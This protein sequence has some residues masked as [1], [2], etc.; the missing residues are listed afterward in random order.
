MVMEIAKNPESTLET[1]TLGVPDEFNF[2]HCLKFLNRSTKECLHR[3]HGSSWIKLVK[4]SGQLV[5]I[6][7]YAVENQLYVDLHAPLSFS[8]KQQLIEYLEQVFDLR[9]D[10]TQFYLAMVQDP[11]MSPL[12]DS[13]HGLRLIGMPELFEALC[14]S[15]IG[16][17]INLSF[18]YDLKRRLVEEKGEKLTVDQKDYYLFPSPFVVA[19]L[20]PE[21]FVPWKFSAAKAKYLLAVAQE[22][23]SGGLTK[24]ELLQMPFQQAFAR[25]TSIKGIGPWSANYVL[26]KCLRHPAAF[27]STD[28]GLQ[29]AVKNLLALDRKPS[30]DE[31]EELRTRWSPWE[32]YATFYL[33]HS[34]IP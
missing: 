27:P 19:S 33:W 13:Y 4:L 16:Q 7:V 20:N 6:K 31:L 24:E 34:L 11:I 2:D 22:M 28:V 10:L 12:V 32:G 5:L 9:R 25:L 1:I 21:D 8:Q 29:N 17:Q 15:V 30:M 18:A 26:M 3:V 14:W 23:A